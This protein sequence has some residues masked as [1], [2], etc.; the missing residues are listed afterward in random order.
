MPRIVDQDN[1][2]HDYCWKHMPN[3]MVAKNRFGA[4]S[5]WYADHVK[6]DETKDQRCEFCGAELNKEDN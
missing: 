5:I 2:A 1:K 4:S 6:Y 3:N